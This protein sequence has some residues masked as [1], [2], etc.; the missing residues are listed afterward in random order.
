MSGRSQGQLE[1]DESSHGEVVGEPESHGSLSVEDDP[2]GT[3]SPADLAGSASSDDATVGYQ[4]SA[5][6]ADKI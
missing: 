3:R 5:S 6:E 2:D 1:P 4:P